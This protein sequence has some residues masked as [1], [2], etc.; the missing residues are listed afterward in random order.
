[1]DFSLPIFIIRFTGTVTV[2]DCQ[3]SPVCPIFLAAARNTLQKIEPQTSLWSNWCSW[4][5]S[6]LYSGWSPCYSNSSCSSIGC[7]CYFS[8]TFHTVSKCFVL[9]RS[10]FSL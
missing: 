3:C 5:C 6:Y 9:F 2:L 7:F 1:L 8:G 4:T 10:Y